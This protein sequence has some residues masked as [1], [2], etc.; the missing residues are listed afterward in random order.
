M[1]AARPERLSDAINPSP[2]RFCLYILVS[3]TFILFFLVRWLRLMFAIG[4]TEG[5]GRS[6]SSLIYNIYYF[7]LNKG[8]YKGIFIENVKIFGY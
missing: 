8:I 1:T 3:G 7:F 5:E 6:L 4:V 2:L